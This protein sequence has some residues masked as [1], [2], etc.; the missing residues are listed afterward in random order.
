MEALSVT[1]LYGQ[2][3]GKS[4]TLLSVEIYHFQEQRGTN[5]WRTLEGFAYAVFAMGQTIFF[6]NCRMNIDIL[7]MHRVEKLR[8]IVIKASFSSSSFSAMN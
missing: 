5:W 3:P 8:S 1:N 2:F 7:F 4:P 6:V